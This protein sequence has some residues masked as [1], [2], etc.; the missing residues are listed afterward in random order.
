[1]N[2]HSVSVLI[3]NFNNAKY[4]N[5]SIKSCVNQ[6]YKKIEVLVYDDKSTDS[7]VAILKKYKN[8]KV[9]VFYNN[10][11]KTNFAAIDAKN[12]Y[13]NLIKFS[14]GKIIFLLDSDDYFKKNKVKELIKIY[15]KNNQ[16][17]FIQD[18]PTIYSKGKKKIKNKNNFLSFWPYLAP[19]SCISF[20]KKLFN[21]FKKRNKNFENN[22]KDVWFGFR[23]GVFAYFKDRSFYSFNKSF[24]NYTS[25]GESKKYTLFNS[26]WFNRRLNSFYY[27]KKINQG[28]N[29]LNFN[30]DYLFTKIISLILKFFK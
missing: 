1:M 7:S 2:E 10:S 13:Y 5:R 4:L 27:L 29:N 12:G 19:E 8:K 22:F 11:N 28:Y 26:N 6:S 30:F 20:R 21:D 16:I 24:T 14:K 9:K 23:L 18:L 15:K 17:N 3:L 25:Y